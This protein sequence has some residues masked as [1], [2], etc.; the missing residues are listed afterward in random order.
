[1]N[2][3]IKSNAKAIMAFLAG[4]LALNLTPE[5]VMRFNTAA[6]LDVPVSV[7]S[8]FVALVVAACVWIVPNAKK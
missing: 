4:W 2:N 6:G 8:A 7:V 3:L 5:L 1:M